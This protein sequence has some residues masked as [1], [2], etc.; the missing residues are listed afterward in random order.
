[1]DIM[2]MPDLFKEYKSICCLLIKGS[3]CSVA[4]TTDAGEA[5]VKRAGGD[6]VMHAP[7]N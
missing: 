7:Q 5:P 3:E 4:K 2:L 1:M 6:R